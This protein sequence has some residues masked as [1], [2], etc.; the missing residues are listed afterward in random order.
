MPTNPYQAI[1]FDMDGLIVDSEELYYQ[2]YNRTLQ[3]HQNS[4]PRE[5]Y[6]RFVGRPV[7]DNSRET[8]T[9]YQL[10]ISPE[11]FQ[12]AWMGRFEQSVSDPDQIELMPGFLDFLSQAVRKSYPLAIASS[13]HR[14]R[15]LT[16]LQNGVLPHLE[17]D[18]LEEVFSAL[19]SGNEVE[20]SKPDPAIFLLAASRLGASPEACLALED[21]EAGVQSAKAAGMTALAIPNFFTNHQNHSE[22]DHILQSLTQAIEHI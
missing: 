3:D 17:S 14:P 6:T 11:G 20:N 7:E 2:S 22:A 4:I 10:S 13:T 9:R 1:I 19:V 8:V 18:S 12:D 5:G 21:S 16:T 15:M